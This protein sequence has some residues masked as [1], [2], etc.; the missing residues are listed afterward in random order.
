MKLNIPV[1]F[2]LS[3]FEDAYNIVLIVLGVIAVLTY[4]L[5]YVDYSDGWNGCTRVSVVTVGDLNVK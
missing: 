4:C 3:Q 1:S 5:V 2:D